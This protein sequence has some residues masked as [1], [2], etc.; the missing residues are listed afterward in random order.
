MKSK[1]LSEQERNDSSLKHFTLS[2]LDLR[3]VDLICCF[4]D[5]TSTHFEG[6][7]AL[8][9]LIF[10]QNKHSPD[11]YINKTHHKAKHSREIL[12]GSA[13]PSYVFSSRNLNIKNIFE[14]F[15]ENVFFGFGI[16]K[17]KLFHAS[18]LHNLLAFKPRWMK[19]SFS[20]E[21]RILVKSR[22]CISSSVNWVL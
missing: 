21:F 11:R 15:L 2:W 18:Y 17:T 22:Y 8:S 7:T 9:R 20:E 13:P 5:N 3:R 14:E 16:R 10:I 4:D 19:S 6:F 12:V 1:A